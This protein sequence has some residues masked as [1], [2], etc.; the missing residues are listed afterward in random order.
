MA[1]SMSGS[2]SGSGSGSVLTKEACIADSGKKS[3][4]SDEFKI[5]EEKIHEYWRINKCNIVSANLSNENTFMATF[6]YPYMNGYL[7]LGHGFTMSKYDFA[8]RFYRSLGYDV[9]Q[10]FSFHITGMPIMAAADKLIEDIN[11]MSQ[12]ISESDLP[13]SSQYKIMKK[14]GIDESEIKNFTDPMYWGTYFS[15]HA[16][17]TLDRFGISYDSS[18]SFTTTNANPIYDKFVQWQ[19]RKLYRKNA[20]KFGSRYDL[21]SIKDAQPCLGHERSSGEDAVVQMSYL[22]KFQIPDTNDYMIVM[23]SRPETLCGVSNLWINNNNQ[24]G[25]YS[26]I[27]INVCDRIERWICQEY[28]IINLMNQY[29]ETDNFHIKSYKVISQIY[30]SELEGKMVI[31]PY[32]S[33]IIPI[34]SLNKYQSINQ[35]LKI[36]MNKG[37]GISMA[38]PSES[39]ID[40]MGYIYAKLDNKIDK[41][42]IIEPIIHVETDKYTGNM[43]AVDMIDGVK[44]DT[45]KFPTVFDQTYTTIPIV[46]QSDMQKIRDFCYVDST[47][48]S[49]M[50]IEPFVNK[51]IIEA[52]NTIIIDNSSYIIKYYE[53]DQEAFSRSGD[54]LIVAKMD[55]WFI[56]YG[57]KEWKT[58]ALAHIESM[59]FTDQ[60]VKNGLIRSVNWLDQWPCSRTYGLGSMFPDDIMDLIESNTS[61]KHMIDSLSDS[62]I[63][64]ALY[65]IYHLFDLHNIK[66]E[67]LTDDVW[68]Y[69]FL[70]ENYDNILYEKFKP[71]RDEFIHWYPVNLRVSAKDLI[72]NHLSMCIFNH[73]MIWDQDFIEKYKIYYPEKYKTIR[74]FGPISYQINGYISVQKQSSDT[75]KTEKTS[76]ITIEKMSKSKGN[77]RTLD[78]AIDAYTSDSIRF[79]FASASTGTDDSY[80]DQDLCTRMVEKFYKE[81]EWINEKLADISLNKYTVEFNKI[82]EMIMNEMLIICQDVLDA[83]KKMNFLEVVTKGFHIFQGIRDIYQDININNPLNMNQNVLKTFIKAQLIMMYPIIPHFCTMF[84]NMQI[85]QKT[86]NTNSIHSSLK[87]SNLMKLFSDHGFSTIDINKH[88]QHKYLIQMAS[89]ISLHILKKKNKSPV[90]KV[91]IYVSGDISD[92]I[93]KIACYIFREEQGKKLDYSELSSISIKIN[94]T[95][96]NNPKNIGILT[97]HYKQLESITEEYGYCV[98]DRIISDKCFEYKTLADNLELYMK[99]KTTDTYELEFILY[100]ETTDEKITGIKIFEPVIRYI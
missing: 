75:N 45:S 27:E 21:Y 15:S 100:N 34:C 23:T 18:R 70:L 5:E 91:Q 31:N 65:T 1:D 76:G 83:Y 89:D 78:Q 68:D 41:M 63:Y 9:L 38:V 87:M 92:P 17:K 48:F 11:K 85:F 24:H 32:N 77:F 98:F 35:M 44:S 7:H 55:Q 86:M 69:I 81:R 56:D 42:H 54:K 40:Y 66:S 51:T 29:R 28:N 64:M 73:V 50:L 79:T 61:A 43:M 19:F 72:N 97:K 62:T 46:S 22:V 95:L 52:R 93:N 16:K 58:S 49:Q 10:P 67:E 36:N 71:F 6:P 59:H 4:K 30:G 53:P 99:K 96:M 25:L 12:G 60:I 82:D 88:W 14:M 39:P 57:N 37:T 20:L 13:D 8:C 74:S 3:W 47:N 33:K 2:G 80:F 94:P 90:K 84:D 26:L